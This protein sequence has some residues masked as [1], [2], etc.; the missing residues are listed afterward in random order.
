MGGPGRRAP[1]RQ[2][3]WPAR[4]GQAACWRSDGPGL[5]ALARC[6]GNPPARTPARHHQAAD[7]QQHAQHRPADRQGQAE[8]VELGD[9]LLGVRRELA[10]GGVVVGEGDVDQGEDLLARIGLQ[11]LVDVLRPLDDLPGAGL[12]PER[13]D[14]AVD[15][16][17]V[18]RRLPRHAGQLAAD[19]HRADLD[20][21]EALLEL[22]HGQAVELLLAQEPGREGL[23]GGEVPERVVLLL[24]VERELEDQALVGRVLTAAVLGL[25]ADPVERR[26][27]LVGV[28]HATVG[29]VDGGHEAVPHGRARRPGLDVAP[30]H[31]DV[32]ELEVGAHLEGGAVEVAARAD[33]DR[34]VVLVERGLLQPGVGVEAHQQRKEQQEQPDEHEHDTNSTAHQNPPAWSFPPSDQRGPNTT[35]TLFARTHRLTVRG[36]TRRIRV[37]SG[38]RREPH[39]RP[40]IWTALMQ[41]HALDAPAAR[42]GSLLRAGILVAPLMALGNGLNYVYNI[43]MARLLGP[44]GYGALGALLALALIASVPGLALQVVVARHTAL[45]A[46]DRRAVA[47]LWSATLAGVVLA[48]LALGLLVAAASPLLAGYLRLGSIAPAAGK[49]AAGV[50]LVALGTGV[51][52]AIAA[53]AVGSL[54]AVLLAL[55]W[56]RPGGRSGRTARDWARLLPRGLGREVAAATGG[57][58]GLFVLANVDVLLARHHLGAAASGL[59]AAGAVVAKIAY[60]APQFVV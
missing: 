22:V 1:P 12:D 6:R 16:V 28:D 30:D 51:D 7:H 39:S 15:D 31:P 45:R 44:A 37:T 54:A 56:V 42:A 55:V 10:H 52:G 34:L 8:H 57:I 17:G 59:Y 48:G 11:H 41:S 32:L 13:P 23:L 19:L 18:R 2:A 21:A 25:R 53:V 33:G 60:W 9:V 29:Q 4:A 43:V 47:E 50:A 49:L 38:G 5:T 46:G 36:V 20:A 26:P 27:L 14:V 40:R 35:Q 3:R 58:L 24:D